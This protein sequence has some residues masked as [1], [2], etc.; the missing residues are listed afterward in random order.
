[1]DLYVNGVLEATATNQKGFV[2]PTLSTLVIGAR[3]TAD[4]E[5]FNGLLDDV[6]VYNTALSA[7]DVLM[8]AGAGRNDGAV[9]GQLSSSTT[10]TWNWTQLLDQT[11]MIEDLSF[12]LFTEPVTTLAEPA[13]QV[14]ESNGG[15]I[16]I[17]GEEKKEEKE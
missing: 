1:M 9:L 11:G 17:F 12:M 4:D 10:G 6:R 16:I 5:Y 13:S 14:T 2:T 15:E 7:D 3:G 8:L